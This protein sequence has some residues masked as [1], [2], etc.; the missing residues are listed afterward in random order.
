[1]REFLSAHEVRAVIVEQG[2]GHEQELRAMLGVDP[3][4]EGGVA[5]YRLPP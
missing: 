3:T 5:V 4:M 1:V 2:W